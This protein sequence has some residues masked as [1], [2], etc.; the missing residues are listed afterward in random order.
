MILWATRGSRLV[1]EV[2]WTVLI[3]PLQLQIFKESSLQAVQANFQCPQNITKAACKKQ[4]RQNNKNLADV[5]TSSQL[6]I[7]T[8]S[9]GKGHRSLASRII[10]GALE[11]G[12][13]GQQLRL[14]SVIDE[15]FA[16]MIIN[17]ADFMKCDVFVCTLMSNYC[18][19]LDELRSTVGRKPG[20]L[21][22]DLSK[23]TCSSPPCYV[24]SHGRQTFDFR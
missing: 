18:R 14:K 16:S 1:T 5:K 3:N 13:L 9:T 17:L 12:N 6:V 19:L 22:G 7:E 20:A 11:L 10:R 23:E 2:K 24:G 8:N 21:F 4:R 15:E